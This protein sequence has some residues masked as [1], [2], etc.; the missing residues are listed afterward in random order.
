MGI[1]NL[2]VRMD[3]HVFRLAEVSQLRAALLRAEAGR[4]IVIANTKRLSF[5]VEIAKTLNL[6]I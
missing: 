5:A 4:R 6:Q 1:Q 2:A 3:T